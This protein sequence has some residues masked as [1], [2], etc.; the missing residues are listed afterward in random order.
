MG[1]EDITENCEAE[2]VDVGGGDGR[3][4]CESRR[5]GRRSEGHPTDRSSPT[6]VGWFVEMRCK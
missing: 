1:T 5:S 2:S 6:A 3:Q 4:M